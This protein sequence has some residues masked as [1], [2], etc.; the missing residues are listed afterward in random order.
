M[1]NLAH[2]I[3]TSANYTAARIVKLF[4]L[5][6][7]NEKSKEQNKK[8]SLIL[9]KTH[10]QFYWEQLNNRTQMTQYL[11]CKKVLTI[12]VEQSYFSAKSFSSWMNLT[13]VRPWISKKKQRNSYFKEKISKRLAHNN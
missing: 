3:F 6:C 10:A 8:V 1:E 13:W 5:K 12:A 9:R 2:E 11:V 7:I 4:S